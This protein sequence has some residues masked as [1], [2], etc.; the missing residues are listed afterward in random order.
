M[1]RGGSL[2]RF[3][4]A[5]QGTAIPDSAVIAKVWPEPTRSVRTNVMEKMAEATGLPFRSLPYYLTPTWSWVA[6]WIGSLN[7]SRSPPSQTLLCLPRWR[8]PTRCVGANVKEK[9]VGTTGLPFR[10]QTL[11]AWHQHGQGWQQI[12]KSIQ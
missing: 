9:M 4:E 5:I 2:N 6:A 10:S 1:V 7:L 11:I 3:L 12:L 8:K